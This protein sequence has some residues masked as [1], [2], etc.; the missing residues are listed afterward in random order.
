MAFRFLQVLQSLPGTAFRVLQVLQSLPGTAFRVFQVRPSGSYKFF[1]VFQ[2]R[3]SGS[4]RYGL[5]GLTG[6]SESSRYSLQGLPRT[7]FRVF[8]VLQSS[9]YGFRVVQVRLSVFQ[10]R[11]LGSFRY[12]LQGFSC[13]SVC[14][15]RPSESSKYGLQGL[16]GTTLR[17]FKV[18]PSV[19]SRYGFQG[20]AGTAFRVFQEVVSS[21]SVS[22]SFWGFQGRPAGELSGSSGQDFK[23]AQLG[24]SKS[25]AWSLQGIPG[26][27]FTVVQEVVSTSILES[28]L[29]RDFGV[30]LEEFQSLSGTISGIF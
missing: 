5:Q 14:Q 25:P 6:S 11:P 8:H 2:V 23:A 29:A 16:P 30:F 4:S 22:C 18:R 26:G 24:L 15:V 9:R 17:I 7:A 1:R 20:L 21:S 3:P 19:S 12:G 28:Q 13:T 10:V 27:A